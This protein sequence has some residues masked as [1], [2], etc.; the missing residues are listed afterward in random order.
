M[1]IPTRNEVLVASL[2]SFFILSAPPL[3]AQLILGARETAM[4][5]AVTAIQGA[6]F[7]AF[8]NPAALHKDE[9]GMSFYSIR[10]YGISE[11]TDVAAQIYGNLFSIPVAAGIHHFGGSNY[12]ETR[13]KTSV[14]V[15]LTGSI[16]I[17]G[18]TTLTSYQF[19]GV[20]QNR[21]SAA[22]DAGFLWKPS[23]QFAAGARTVNLIGGKL[24]QAAQPAREIAVGFLYR[25]AEEVLFTADLVDDV[26]YDASIRAGTE[27]MIGKMI[28]LR[29]GITTAPE[30]ASLGV[31]LYLGSLKANLVMQRHSVGALGMSPGIDLQWRF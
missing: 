5:Q 6:G 4:G 2:L 19:G 15:Q 18:A 1:K 25:P 8:A 9:R 13:L 22:L 10:Y 12:Q 3:C 31:G 23:E 20:Y 24:P 7:S 16:S 11:L 26:R 14:A 17:G 28:A 27:F 30:T 29:A 21:S